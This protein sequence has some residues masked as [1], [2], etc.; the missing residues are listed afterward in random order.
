MWHARRACGCEDD[1]HVACGGL[2]GGWHGR[3]TR[4]GQRADT[5]H[6]MQCVGAG[7]SLYLMLTPVATMSRSSMA[8]SS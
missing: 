6:G 3:T 1:S 4:A 2:G 8:A 5:R 7:V